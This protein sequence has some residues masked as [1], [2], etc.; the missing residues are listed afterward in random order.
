MSVHAQVKRI[1]T[2]GGG[3]FGGNT[4]ENY[5]MYIP[6]T[7]DLNLK[8]DKSTLNENIRNV[9]ELISSEERSRKQSETTITNSLSSL[10]TDLSK[11]ADVSKVEEKIKEIT[12][13]NRLAQEKSAL[14]K[15][16]SEQITKIQ[17]ACT[18]E[19]NKI[20]TEIK[21]FQSIDLNKDLERKLSPLNTLLLKTEEKLN[22]ISSELNNLGV[23]K[24]EIVKI[25]K[26]FQSRKN[27]IQSTLQEIDKKKD[28]FNNLASQKTA[29]IERIHQQINSVQPK[30]SDE[31]KS[32]YENEIQSIL[33]EIDKKKD[34]V[35][36]L[37]SQKTA[38]IKDIYQQ[39]ISIQSKITDEI[40]LQH[41]NYDMLMIE[42]NKK[43]TQNRKNLRWSIV[44]ICIGVII[45]HII[46]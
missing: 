21:T 24:E 20:S 2:Q 43:M 4:T 35:N 1:I 12:D 13:C 8:A 45:L 3:F 34:D 28:D 22:T 25:D 11:K 30:I 15:L 10:K 46:F 17:N 29:E 42:M 26:Q 7:P 9:K 19:R 5:D 40:K 27:E 44:G 38:E 16:F 37:A 33:Q 23:I 14:E 31:I 41:K 39:I 36:N 6:E 18:E 32:Q